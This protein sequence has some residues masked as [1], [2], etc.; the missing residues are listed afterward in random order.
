MEKKHLNILSTKIA[1]LEQ[2]EGDPVVIL[3]G[4]GANIESVMPIVN[5]LSES[6]KV[7]AY[8]APGFGE[9]DDPKEVLST[10]DYS[11][12]L[13][14]FLKAKEID[15]A[16]F[17]GHSFGGK[18]LGIF[19]AKNPDLVEKLVLID[20]SGVKPK[21]GLNYYLKVYSFKLLR[22]IYTRLN[23][24]KGKEKALENFYKKFGSEDY[25]NAQGIMRKTFVKVVNENTDKY[26]SKIK[27]PTLL[28]WGEND[29][30]TPL[31]MAKVHEEKI[32]DSGLVILKGAGHY[33]YLDD[34]YTFSAVIKS[35]LG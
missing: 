2:G 9:S 7:Y 14:E 34:Y 25:Q 27:A 21:R 33:S 8:D 29:E 28:V 17:M 26:F 10:E 30:D 5:L 12:Y 31:Y 35:F 16:V 23:F 24:L 15:R 32:K 19:A 20:A 18:T 3:H 4:W 11:S 1:Y 6:H 22:F 13:E